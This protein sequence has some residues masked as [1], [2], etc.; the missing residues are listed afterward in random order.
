MHSYPPHSRPLPQTGTTKMMRTWRKS[1]TLLPGNLCPSYTF[2]HVT[3]C[4]KNPPHTLEFLR[5]FRHWVM[6]QNFL[7]LGKEQMMGSQMLLPT[8]VLK[9]QTLYEEQNNN[10][11]SFSQSFIQIQG[12]NYAWNV[13]TSTSISNATLESKFRDYNAQKTNLYNQNYYWFQI[14]F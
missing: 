2:Q 14:V 3:E 4:E 6:V 12:Q 7:L 9:V 1:E 13:H 10:P 11:F 5:G 8:S